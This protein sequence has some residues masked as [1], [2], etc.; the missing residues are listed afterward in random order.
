VKERSFTFFILASSQTPI[1]IIS[2]STNHTESRPI[3]GLTTYRK[4]VDKANPYPYMALMGTYIEAVA[5]A[6]GIPLLIPLGLD[7]DALRVLLSQVDGL[8]LTGGGDIAGEHYHSEHEDFIFNIDPDRDRVELFLA[9]E[10]MA[11]DKPLLAICRGHQ[12]LN[13]ALGGTLYEDVTAWMPGAIKHDYFDLFPRNHTAHAVAIEPDSKL[14]TALGRREAQV[15]SLHHQ[16]I[17]DLAPGLVAV[18]HA[19]DGLIESVEGVDHPFAVGVQWHPENLVHDDPVMLSL[20]RGLVD[21][22]R[23]N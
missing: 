18:A 2:M 3:I 21:A 1:Y 14:A 7:E 8:V 15:N 11:Q 10:A 23:A 4:M 20:F 13:V 12:V 9:R 6:G 16:G 5:A 17:R 22:A 19:P